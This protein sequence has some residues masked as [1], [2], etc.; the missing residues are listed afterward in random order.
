MT[1][2]GDPKAFQGRGWGWTAV[3]LLVL[4]LVLDLLAPKHA[5]FAWEAAGGFFAAWGFVACAVLVLLARVL[6]RVMTRPEDYYDR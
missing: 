2:Q 5:E 4:L 6:R 1:S 3:A